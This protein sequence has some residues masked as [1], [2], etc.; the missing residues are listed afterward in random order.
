VRLGR[1]GLPDPWDRKDLLES[2]D[3]SD[4]KGRRA[5]PVQPARRGL[6][7]WWDRKDLLERWDL[8]DHK[9]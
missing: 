1:R 3:L 6:L 9:G 4:H 2:W 7:D 8:S 5:T